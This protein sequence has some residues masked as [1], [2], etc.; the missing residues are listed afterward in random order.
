MEETRLLTTAEVAQRLR[1]HTGTVAKWCRLGEIPRRFIEKTSRRG[2]YRIREE[3]VRR[4]EREPFQ[5]TRPLSA[6]IKARRDLSVVLAACG[7]RER[8]G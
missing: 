5:P 6:P 3:W 4:R 1:V 2:N 8:I 7:K